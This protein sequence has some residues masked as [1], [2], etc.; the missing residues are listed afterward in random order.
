M[1]IGP[2][3]GLRY[4]VV[5]IAEGHAWLTPVLEHQGQLYADHYRDCIVAVDRLR[6]VGSMFPQWP[7]PFHR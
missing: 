1:E 5:A 6:E 4:R 3:R 7:A 2:N